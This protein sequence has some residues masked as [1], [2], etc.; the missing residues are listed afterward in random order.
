MVTEPTGQGMEMGPSRMSIQMYQT[1]FMRNN[2]VPSLTV[3]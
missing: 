2:F 1:L 3:H